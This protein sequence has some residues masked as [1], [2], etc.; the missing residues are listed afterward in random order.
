ML[1]DGIGV[2]ERSRAGPIPHR[3]RLKHVETIRFEIAEAT[4]IAERSVVALRSCT[5]AIKR[6][7]QLI[8]AIEFGVR[9]MLT[10][11]NYRNEDEIQFSRCPPLGTD[12][13]IVLASA[14]IEDI[15]KRVSVL[16][17]SEPSGN[18]S[19]GTFASIFERWMLG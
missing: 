13:K 4:Q 8:I 12:S 1:E 6:C 5:H 3:G 17:S 11:K 15:A 19:D 7:P 14:A 2:V 16:L 10:G 9:F 18:V